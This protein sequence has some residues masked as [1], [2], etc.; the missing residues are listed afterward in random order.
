MRNDGAY[1]AS[2]TSATL[3]LDQRGRVPSTVEIQ[4][5]TLRS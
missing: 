4:S 5:S 2:P 1:A 3:P